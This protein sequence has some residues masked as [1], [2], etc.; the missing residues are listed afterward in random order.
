MKCPVLTRV[1]GSPSLF[2]I[3]RI[4]TESPGSVLQDDFVS[5]TST[6]CRKGRARYT[7]DGLLP[8]NHPSPSELI[9][10]SPYSKSLL[11]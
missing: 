11:L 2:G 7:A 10:Q 1:E 9:P 8:A 3:C 4:P 5:R 6:G